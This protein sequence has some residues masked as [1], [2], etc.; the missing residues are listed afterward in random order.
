MWYQPPFA[1]RRLFARFLLSVVLLA[2][3]LAHGGTPAEDSVFVYDVFAGAPDCAAIR[4]RLARLPLRPT[5]ILSVEQGAEFVLDRPAG[6]R[7]LRCALAELRHTSRRARAMLLQ[8]I[9]FL[10]NQEEAVRRVRR[11]AQLASRTGGL[12]GM[13]VDIEPYLDPRWACAPAAVRRD[14]MASY[15]ELLRKLRAAKGRLPLEAAVPW[16]FASPEVDGSSVVAAL[17]GVYVMVYGDEGGPLVGGRAQRVL[18]RVPPKGGFFDGTRVHVALAPYEAES[19]AH[20]GREIAHLRQRY[21]HT[22]GWAGVAVFHA[23]SA[24]GV[25]LVRSLAGVV[26][27]AHGAAVA[28]AV[29]EFSGKKAQTDVCGQF[30]FRGMTEAEGELVV[31][32]PGFRGVTVKLRLAPPGAATEVPP[33]R[34]EGVTRS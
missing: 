10:R 5:V 33:I 11:L 1:M 24:Y 15:V 27:D 20:F 28:G 4:Q 22:R 19:P 12:A 14:I 3:P 8:D 31:S 7:Q 23:G 30:S 17:D 6:E 16:W 13:V 34:L 18:E 26:Q 32:K 29:V 9:G 21:A 25:P 2:T